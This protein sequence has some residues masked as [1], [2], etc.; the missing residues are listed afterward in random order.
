MTCN[1]HYDHGRGQRVGENGDALAL[2]PDMVPMRRSDDVGGRMPAVG[3]A[4]MPPPPFAA[5]I[6]ALGGRMSGGAPGCVLIDQRE[7]ERE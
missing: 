3:G 1:G 2:L 6:D 7:R 5:R 4:A